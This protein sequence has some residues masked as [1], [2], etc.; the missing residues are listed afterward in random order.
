MPQIAARSGDLTPDPAATERGE[1]QKRRSGRSGMPLVAAGFAV[2]DALGP[3]AP[4]V[5]TRVDA[6]SLT[7]ER[8]FDYGK[9]LIVW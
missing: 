2:P 7:I 6:S 4:S 9:G 3:E 5:R 1:W 8:T